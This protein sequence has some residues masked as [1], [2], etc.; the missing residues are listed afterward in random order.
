MF[1]TFEEWMNERLEKDLKM[2]IRLGQSY[3]NRVRPR[4]QHRELYFTKDVD[5]AW[6]LIYKIEEDYQTGPYSK[7]NQ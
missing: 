7:E 5:K 6:S 4:M 3:M 2:G 1:C